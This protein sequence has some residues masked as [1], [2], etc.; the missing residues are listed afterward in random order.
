MKE[1]DLDKILLKKVAELAMKD[2]IPCLYRRDQ[3]EIIL[4]LRYN[5][6]RQAKRPYRACGTA[7]KYKKK[8]QRA[9]NVNPLRKPVLLQLGI[10][11]SM[12]LFVLPHL[13]ILF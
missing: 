8:R 4:G 11:S 1:L 12:A 3:Q 10:V 13:E 5:G 6:R 2:G 7:F 9:C